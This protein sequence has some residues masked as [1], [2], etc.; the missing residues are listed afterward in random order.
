MPANRQ[1]KI[2]HGGRTFP[3]SRSSRPRCTVTHAPLPMD[4]DQTK[5]PDGPSCP[6]SFLN[7]PRRSEA[8]GAGPF[9]FLPPRLA[10]PSP[11]LSPALTLAPARTPFCSAW[12]FTNFE[13]EGQADEAR[14]AAEE[15]Q[16]R[17]VSSRAAEA[18]SGPATG[19][20]SACS[21]ARPATLRCPNAPPEHSRQRECYRGGKPSSLC[22]DSLWHPLS[23]WG[24]S[25]RRWRRSRQRCTILPSVG[26]RWTGRCGQMC[27]AKSVRST[28]AARTVRKTFMEGQASPPAWVRGGTGLEVKRPVFPRP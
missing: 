5:S 7:I 25:S 24:A 1:K 12:R 23:L 14:K 8:T 3:L 21:T 26:S 15:R 9:S 2:R 27:S 22:G 4:I 28:T 11:K 13:S 6:S 20:A 10:R 19:S 17:N 16:Q 18:V